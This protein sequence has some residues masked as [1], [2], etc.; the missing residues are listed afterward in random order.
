MIKNLGK[1]SL[2]S[3]S[4]YFHFILIF[5]LFLRWYAYWVWILEAT[6]LIVGYFVLDLWSFFFFSLLCAFW[7]LDEMFD[8][9]NNLLLSSF[10]CFNWFGFVLFWVILPFLK[11]TDEIMIWDSLDL[12]FFFFP[13]FGILF[14]PLHSNSF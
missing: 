8:L 10:S 4:S 13:L 2:I 7:L 6:H 1:F 11:L 9:L 5:F 14:S 12:N 3:L